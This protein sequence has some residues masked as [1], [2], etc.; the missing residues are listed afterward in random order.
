MIPD[1][2][3][4]LKMKVGAQAVKRAS[5]RQGGE[6]HSPCPLCGGVDRFAVFPNQEGGALCQKHGLTGT[7]RCMRGCE[8][9]GDLIA[10]FTEIEGLSFKAALAELKIEPDSS[11]RSGCYRPLKA[12]A[13]NGSPSFCPQTYAPPADQWRLAATRLAYDAYSNI[14]KFP[15]IMNWLARRGLAQ[16][17]VDRYALG[18]IEGEARHPEY[19]FRQRASYGLPEKFG[20]DGQP[21]KAF[22]IPRGITIPV[23]DKHNQAL[24]I[25]IRRRDS[26]RTNPRDAKYL[27][28]PQPAPAYSAPLILWPEDAVPDMAVWVIVESELD[29]MAVHYACQGTIGVISVLTAKGKPDAI[30]HV[31]LRK[32]ARILVALDADET[33][34][35]GGNAGAEAWGWWQ[36]I[37]PQARLWPVPLG[38]DPGE[39]FSLGVDLREWIS[40]GNPLRKSRPSVSGVPA[41]VGEKK[42]PARNMGAV[43][44][45]GIA[46]DAGAGWP[47]PENSRSFMEILL[48]ENVTHAALL[49]TQREH[50][51]ADPECLLPCPKTRPP[52]WWVYHRDCVK[53]KCGGHPQCLLPVL[54]SDLFMEALNNA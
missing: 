8:K 47:V 23:L 7:W 35:D 53:F 18:Y 30:A 40:A 33:R 28:V 15:A 20:K 44:G 3:E 39:A 34:P 1:I 12:P 14:Y 27:L 49:K 9:D 45:I 4:L 48:P 19:L 21:L 52:F 42:E 10:W 2:V 43:S 51:L 13:N 32:C 54:Q 31:A 16:P 22:R 50:P 46:G 6:Y 29:A 24:R 25:R 36:D 26:D 38:K 37:Y 17:A 11:S 41:G 5:G